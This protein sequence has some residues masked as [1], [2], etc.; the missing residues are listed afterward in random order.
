MVKKIIFILIFIFLVQCVYSQGS[1]ADILEMSVR[2]V[3][4]QLYNPELMVYV[5]FGGSM[6]L[7]V[8]PYFLSV[9]LYGD[10]GIGADWFALFS[11][12]SYNR[13]D[14]NRDKNKIYNQFGANLGL[15]LYFLIELGIMKFTAFTGYNVIFGQLDSRAP[16]IIHNPIAGASLIFKFIGLEYCYYIPVLQPDNVKFHHISVVFRMTEDLY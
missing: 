10:V 1:S 3:W 4:P 2:I 16:G 7:P 15:R 5:N 9:G 8:I 14:Y 11:N 6:S 12:D 13:D